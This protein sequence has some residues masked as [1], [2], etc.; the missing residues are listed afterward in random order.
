MIVIFILQNI[1]H[2]RKEERVKKH[3]EA[4]EENSKEFQRFLEENE[5]RRKVYCEKVKKSLYIKKSYPNQLNTALLQV[6]SLYENDR[7][8][9][10][11]NKLKE[12]EK[13]QS[14]IYSKQIKEGALAEEREKEIYKEKIKK[15]KAELKEELQKE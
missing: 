13:E 15:Q 12:I 14:E 3:Q 10:L 5:E 4:Y 6:E 8:V 1:H 2:N 7:Q 11:N 9:E